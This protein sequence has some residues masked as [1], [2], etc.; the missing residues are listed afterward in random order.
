MIKKNVIEILLF[1]EVFIERVVRFLVSE[2]KNSIRIEVSKIMNPEFL[3]GIAFNI[4]YCRRKY[5]SGTICKG[6][7]RELAIE[8]LSG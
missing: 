3:L 6:V 1:V 4:A 8:L 5:H 7:I 2:R